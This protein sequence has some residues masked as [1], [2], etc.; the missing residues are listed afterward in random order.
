MIKIE[1]IGNKRIRVKRFYFIWTQKFWRKVLMVKRYNN[2]SFR[3][4]RCGKN[5]SVVG[6]RQ[7]Q[8]TY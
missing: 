7:M 6:I 3:S 2:F 4:Y 1:E 5:M 8:I